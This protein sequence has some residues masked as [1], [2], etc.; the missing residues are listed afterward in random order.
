MKQLKVTE[1]KDWI[2]NQKPFQLI[3]L[4]E[5]YEL[6]ICKIN[7]A[8]HIPMDQILSNTQKIVMDRPVVLF[9]KTGQR[10]ESVIHALETEHGFSNLYSLEGGIMA[11]T[12]EVDVTL[13]RY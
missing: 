12:K 4:R 7:S 2:D 1:L 3:D 10:A 6:D 9:C 13:D 11:W 5:S 8:I